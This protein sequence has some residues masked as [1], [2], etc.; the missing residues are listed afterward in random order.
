VALS[1]HN[2]LIPRIQD[3]LPSSNRPLPEAAK[4]QYDWSR[5][6]LHSRSPVAKC[7]FLLS[8][9]YYSLLVNYYLAIED[10]WLSVNRFIWVGRGALILG[11]PHPI[12]PLGG[13]LRSVESPL[14]RR[15]CYVAAAGASSSP[16][17]HPTCHF[18]PPQ[19]HFHNSSWRDSYQRR[20][21][22]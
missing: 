18:R 16:R 6:A 3:R 2:P 17:S 21:I 7:A 12:C 15:A 1:N 10:L 13:Q 9:D 11:L 4:C 5:P 14:Q 19:N 8:P 20:T 22:R